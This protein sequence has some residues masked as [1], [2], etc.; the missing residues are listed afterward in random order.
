M[1]LER[2]KIEFTKHN[3]KQ[4]SYIIKKQLKA[5]NGVKN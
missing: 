5:M 3:L 4:G 1:K 2:Y